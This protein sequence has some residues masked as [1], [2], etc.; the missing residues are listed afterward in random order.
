MTIGFALAQQTPPDVCT[1]VPDMLREIIDAQS[2]AKL[3]LCGMT[4]LGPARLDFELTF[5]VQGTD[6]ARAFNA[7]NRI[8]LQIQEA[9]SKADIQLA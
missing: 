6:Y 9:F 5:E 8:C 2:D 1:R 3:V 4:G 7:R